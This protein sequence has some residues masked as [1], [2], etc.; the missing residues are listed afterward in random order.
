MQTSRR[1]NFQF[2]TC[3][4]IGC[5]VVAVLFTLIDRSSSAQ[6]SVVASTEHESVAPPDL[7]PADLYERVAPSVVTIVVN[8]EDGQPITTGSGFFIDEASLPNRY[9]FLDRSQSLA[10][11]LTEKGTPTQFGYVLTNYHVIRPAVSANVV[12]SNDDK[13]FVL[14]VIAESESAD[15][16]LLFVSLSSN[17][18]PH[19]IP[20]AL[21]NPR[22][23]TTVYA[24]GSPKGL[25]GSASEGKISGLRGLSPG[26]QWLQTTT[27]IS[28]GSSG[29]PLLLSDGTLAGMTTMFLKDAQ[30]INF[31]I[32]VSEIRKFLTTAEIR[33]RDIAE[34]ASIKWSV[35]SAFSDI[36]NTIGSRRYT[37]AEKNALELLETAE[38][39]HVGLPRPSTR[40]M[41]L[42]AEA[43]ESL[44][45]GLKSLPNEFKYLAHYVAGQA[46]C[47]AA[48]ESAHA[49]NPNSNHIFTQTEFA[50]RYRASPHSGAAFYHLTEATR[51]KPDFAP[52]YQELVNQYEISGDRANALLAA[53]ALVDKVP[54][55]ASAL[56][57]R[58]RCYSELN[59]P[60][61]AKKDLEAAIELSPRDAV[62][63]GKLAKTL[64][65]LG[66]YTEAIAAYELAI[67]LQDFD[68]FKDDYYFD[69]GI[70]YYKVGNFEKAISALTQAKNMGYP[71][72]WCD[73]VIAECTQRKR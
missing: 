67:E 55:C 51:S 46:S 61:S 41:E 23:L 62:F 7:S 12:L 2:V 6:P 47:R 3:I 15:L 39:G 25:D 40:A 44:P 11:S 49:S 37:E 34:G 42:A 65:E 10:K 9:T 4:A 60:E 73:P 71:A 50:S 59:Q 21:E 45:D 18:P 19:G 35:E 52:A 53:N 1:G 68:F 43:G 56:N 16:A 63:H 29:G 66:D 28:P 20:F 57:I 14:R 32:P 54:R 30:N 69:M 70:A 33:T 17:R 64:V 36:R 22:V 48:V 27:P 13:G 72:E 8:D 31:A 58:A 24:F 38:G 5:G 26:E